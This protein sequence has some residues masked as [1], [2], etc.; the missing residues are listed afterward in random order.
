MICSIL[1]LGAVALWL[2]Q[3]LRHKPELCRATSTF[4]T[5]RLIRAQRIASS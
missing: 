2:F 1:K 4:L 5:E 3:S